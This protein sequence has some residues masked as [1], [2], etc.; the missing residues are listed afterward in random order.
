MGRRVGQAQGQKRQRVLLVGR[1]RCGV[2]A[3]LVLAV[4]MPQASPAGKPSPGSGAQ[5]A[6]V[7]VGAGPFTMGSAAG[8]S[9]ER[10]VRRVWLD[11][12][13]VDRLEVTQQDYQRCVGA[14]ACSP[15]R[16]YAGLVGPRLPA[17]GVT[18]HDAHRYCVWAGKR[19]PTEAEWER[20]ARGLDD[21]RLPWGS[22]LSCAR[23]NI[24]SFDGAGL[25]AGHNPGKVVPVGGRNSGASPVGA[26]DMAGN[27]WEWVGDW[28]G[29]YAAAGR[30]NPR[31]PERGKRRVLRGG[32]CCSYFAMPTVTNRHRLDPGFADRDIGFRCARSKGAAVDERRH[33]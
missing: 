8:D 2:R 5:S 17:V 6:M 22:D 16:T 26:L 11:A 12:Y 9:D 18:W 25:C 20:A 23:A 28:Y 3:G 1:R 33:P 10:P 32:S 29:V 15:A 14:G 7:S 27:A 24:G 19:L 13:Q 21:R 31:G 4:L 30:R